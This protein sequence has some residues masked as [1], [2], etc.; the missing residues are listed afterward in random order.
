M[1]ARPDTEPVAG[2]PVD[3]VVPAGLAR[4]GM[5]RDL[6]GRQARSAQ[7]LLGGLVE[8]AL[9]V[10]VR[11]PQ[12]AAL[13]QAPEPRPRLDGQLIDREMAA[14]EA[15]GMGQLPPSGTLPMIGMLTQPPGRFAVKFDIA[16]KD[17]EVFMAAGAAGSAAIYTERLHAIH[18]I[19]KVILRVGSYINYL[20][21]KLH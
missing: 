18:I 16:D 8:L 11:Q 20:V 13:L 14:D 10:V 9:G 19:R 7:D 12:P 5:V 17:K 15:Q 4:R 6:V 21:L 2:A 1:R 3:E